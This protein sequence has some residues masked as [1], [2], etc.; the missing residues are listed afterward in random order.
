[1]L[2]RWL[3]MGVLVAVIAGVAW[4]GLP[5]A[6]KKVAVGDAALEFS[7]PD[8]QGNNQTLPKGDVILL[9]FWATW[10]PPCRQEMP[11]MVELSKKYAAKGL[12]VVAV[13]VDRN[14]KLLNNF[15]TEYKLP[16]LVLHDVDS[17]VSS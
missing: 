13:S 9:N 6:Q 2:G 5:E 8:L 7:L 12:K 10:C 1:M 3:F 17:S 14:A 11:S 15:V 4:F 16:F